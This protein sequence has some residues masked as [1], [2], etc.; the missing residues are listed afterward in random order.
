MTMSFSKAP[1]A[2]RIGVTVFETVH[3]QL[4]VERRREASENG[5]VLADL[6]RES[7]VVVRVPIY[8]PL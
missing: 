5:L 1:R 6:K 3:A 7:I 8:G 4:F 2:C